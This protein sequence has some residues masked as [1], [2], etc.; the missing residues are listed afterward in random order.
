MGFFGGYGS[1]DYVVRHRTFQECALEWRET[2]GFAPRRGLR[3]GDP[4]SPYLF[5]SCVWRDCVIK[6]IEQLGLRHGSR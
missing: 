2:D 4:L 1:L 3:Q 6:L 5:V